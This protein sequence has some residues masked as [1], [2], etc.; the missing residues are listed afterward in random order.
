MF[1]KSK[2]HYKAI[3]TQAIGRV[4]RYGQLKEVN[5][6]RFIARDTIDVEIYERFTGT[7]YQQEEDA[8]ALAKKEP[9]VVVSCR[10]YDLESFVLI[11]H[12]QDVD[13]DVVMDGSADH[14]PS[15]AVASSPECSA[16]SEPTEDNTST[17][18]STREHTPSGSSA[19]DVA[20]VVATLTVTPNSKKKAEATQ[21]D[22]VEDEDGD[23]RLLDD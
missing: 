5:V 14:R 1:A 23:V 8:K 4:R 21:D 17:V 2:E 18:A 12:L 9:I 20:D 6:W 13:D 16:R 3:E 19:G 11:V 15:V 7:N 22:E 10:L